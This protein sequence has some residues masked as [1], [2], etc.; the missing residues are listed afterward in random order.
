MDERKKTGRP[1]PF[2]ESLGNTFQKT[3]RLPKPI[4]EVLEKPETKITLQEMAMNKKFE[5]KIHRLGAEQKAKRLSGENEKT[6]PE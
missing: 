2:D 4:W 3:P 5:E 6:P 1:S